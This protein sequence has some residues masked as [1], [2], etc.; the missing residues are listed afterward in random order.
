MAASGSAQG[1]DAPPPSGELRST[2]S[3]RLPSHATFLAALACIETVVL[4]K[5]LVGNGEP[6]LLFAAAC[7]AVVLALVIG[8]IARARARNE[9][10]TFLLLGAIGAMVVGPVGLLGAS[11]LCGLSLGAEP[12]SPLVAQWYERIALSTSVPD[13]ERLCE[14]VEV[15][16]TLDPAAP[17]PKSFP[18][19]MTTG[20]LDERQA[21]LGQIARHFDLSY[22]PTLEMALASP[23]PMIRVQAAAV[24][25]HISPLMRRMLQDCI[26]GASRAPSGPIEALALLDDLSSLLGSGLLDA[27]ER[28]QAEALARRLGDTVVTALT[29]K[30]LRIDDPSDHARETRLRN[31]LER[32]LIERNLFTEL[33]AQRTAA[34]IRKRHPTARL[35]RLAVAMRDVDSF[36]SELLP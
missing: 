31:R 19:I 23:E 26:S 27:T 2:V 24:A 22:L 8:F 29:Q 20:P 28:Q 11:L 35:Q 30:P 3:R 34:R 33:R 9:D 17:P 4:A 13:E 14:D 36:R 7:H 10:V 25:S 21:V 6:A 5:A 1:E 18:A 15:G 16:R 12:T 32:L